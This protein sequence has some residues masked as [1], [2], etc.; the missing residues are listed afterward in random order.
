M[1]GGHSSSNLGAPS[2]CS[3]SL[4]PRLGE[5]GDPRKEVPNLLPLFTHYLP[6][7]EHESDQEFDPFLSL[8]LA[9]RRIVG[10]DILPL[11]QK[12][13]PRKRRWKVE[14]RWKF[15]WVLS[16]V[17]ANAL[18]AANHPVSKRVRYSRRSGTYSGLSVYWPNFLRT[19]T[20]K[21]AV[22]TLGDLGLL[23]LRNGVYSSTEKLQSTFQATKKLREWLEANKIRS[24]HIIRLNTAPVIV[25][26][27][28]KEGERKTKPL[29]PYDQDDPKIAQMIRAVR[30]YNFFLRQH[31][32]ALDLPERDL[33]A[34]YH[35]PEKAGNPR[36][37]I[38]F[39]DKSLHRVFNN[40]TFEQGGR[41]TG[42]WWINVPAKFRDHLLIDGAP[43]VELDYSG[44]FLRMVY[45][46][47]KLEMKGDPYDLPVIHKLA[48]AQGLKWEAVRSA[49][50]SL[51]NIYLNAE[52][53]SRIG[54]FP[55][56]TRDLPRGVRRPKRIYDM[57]A[58]HHRPIARQ[59]LTGCGLSLMRQESDICG[60]ILSDG[61]RDGI[62]VLPVYD[63]FVVKR[64]HEGWLEQ[65][66]TENYRKRIGFN[67]EIKKKEGREP[68][69][70][71]APKVLS[72][73]VVIGG[74]V[75]RAAQPL[76]HVSPAKPI[77]GSKAGLWEA[78]RAT[79]KLDYQ[80]VAGNRPLETPRGP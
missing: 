46:L 27:G 11:C 26:K 35:M 28:R 44:C 15:F 13:R 21:A 19:P 48:D 71:H 67:P 57:I 53:D 20:L 68:N 52:P 70:S 6:P 61:L 40:G 60:G 37:P 45:H 41:F 55:E 34:M 73:N 10:R 24:E 17:I 2:A 77:E 80:V 23:V 8:S 31:D 30:D 12:A 5:V 72:P 18:R 58:K 25:L 62:V 1:P 38:N 79:R 64:E 33:E 54:R 47:E 43:T 36:P 75:S 76:P 66:M 14:D 51:T 49:V 50:K 16:L 42:A 22:D 7:S 56:I 3:D 63:S 32:I 69:I 78:I 59:F 9:T 29:L 74:N 39:S 4:L 65:A